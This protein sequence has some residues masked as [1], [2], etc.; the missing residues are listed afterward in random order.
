[1]TTN[2]P[3]ER[4]LTDACEAFPEPETTRTEIPPRRLWGTLTTFTPAPA[5]A[6]PLLDDIVEFVTSYCH[7]S[8]AAA[9]AIALW[10]LHA[11]ALD[12]FEIT[13]YLAITS[14]EK[15]SGK[16]T[17]L[18]TI[19]ALVPRPWRVVQP[20]EAVLFR[21]IEQ[22]RPTLLLDETDTVFRAGIEKEGL[23]ALL[24]AGNEI[25]ATVPRCVGKSHELV[26]FNVFCAKVLAGIG[27]R[28]L[29]DTVRDRS[30]SISMKRKR[31]EEPVA[32]FRRREVRE[33]AER[34]R[35]QIVDWALGALDELGERVPN[36]PEE[37]DDR[38]ADIWEPLLAIADLASGDWPR[39]GRQAALQLSNPRQREDLS[40]GTELLT[41][42]KLVFDNAQ[43]QSLSTTELLHAISSKEESAFEHVW[44]TREQAPARGA[45]NRLASML[46]E[47]GIRSHD[48]RT[49]AGVRKGYHRRD[50]ADAWERH[51]SPACETTSDSHHTTE[52]PSAEALSAETNGR[53]P[54]GINNET[55]RRLLLTHRPELVGRQDITTL[56]E[57]RQIALL[58]LRE[59]GRSSEAGR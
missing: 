48:L 40:L 34:L 44:D 14:A 33:H 32:R 18:R 11:E 3:R 24:N 8:Q 45:A 7:L 36:L 9:D 46:R 29:P 30:I 17:L 4:S 12:A 13:P 52:A 50:F 16:T 26:N 58:Y 47:Y 15:R 42:I 38:A 51:L 53:S 5:S 1:M 2:E 6:A 55:L 31:A 56:A 19:E 57:R 10:I 25:D 59:E 27:E 37:L 41:A 22:D 39:R 20:S 49:R 54:I 28:H 35:E 23:R 43:A 21:K